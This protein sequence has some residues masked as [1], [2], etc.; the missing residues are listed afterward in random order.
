LS[1]GPVPSALADLLIRDLYESPGGGRPSAAFAAL[2]AAIDPA[3]AKRIASRFARLDAL[4]TEVRGRDGSALRAAA[5]L[6]LEI[7]RAL[8]AAL[9]A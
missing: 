3:S 5:D 4:E 1:E 9:E 6:A 7:G 8:D 2:A